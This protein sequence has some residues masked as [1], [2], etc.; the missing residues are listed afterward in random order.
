MNT[1]SEQLPIFIEE[2]QPE[3]VPRIVLIAGGAIMLVFIICIALASFTKSPSMSKIDMPSESALAKPKEE[4]AG[5][6][7][8]AEVYGAEKPPPT[9]PTP[10]PSA[11]PTPTSAP[12]GDPTATPTPTN[13]PADPTDTPTPEPTAAPTQTP[14]P[15]ETPTETPTP[16]P[17]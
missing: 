12:A 15:T 5:A 17:E 8:Q 1:D 13:K 10:K 7:T 16:T 9:T 6:N 4:V 14:T 2:P 3:S 11:T